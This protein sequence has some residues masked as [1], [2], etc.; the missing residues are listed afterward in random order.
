MRL[1][2]ENGHGQMEGQYL[3]QTGW[4]EMFRQIK[5]CKQ[6]VLLSRAKVNG[7][8][9]SAMRNTRVIYAAFLCPKF[10]LRIS[11]Q[12]MFLWISHQNPVKKQYSV[13]VF[14]YTIGSWYVCS[15]L[16]NNNFKTNMAETK[17][18]IISVHATDD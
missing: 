9:G 10:K 11:K 17:D 16:K 8:A 6:T 12:V 13:S 1:V 5:I 2:L 4:K 3:L 18:Y 15:H 14:S 7:W